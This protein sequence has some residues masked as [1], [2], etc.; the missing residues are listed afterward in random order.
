MNFSEIEKKWQKNWENSECFKSKI[1]EEKPKYYVLEM[2]PYPSGKIHIG[3]LRNYSMGDLLA[4]FHRANGKNVL[5]PMGWDA[6]GLPAENAA[7][8]NN[9][10]PQEW[11]NKNIELMRSQIKAMGNSYD[12]NR[13]INTSSP[14]YYKHEQEFFINLLDKGIAYQ[15]KAIVNWDPVDQTVLANEQVENGRGWRSGALVE[16]KELNGWFLKI[17][18]YAEELLQDIPTKLSE[19]PE[20][21]KHMQENWI[22]K[23]YGAT[24][25]FPIKG[26]EKSLEIYTTR[27]ET[28]FGATFIAVNPE[29][30]ILQY[31]NNDKK[32]IEFIEKCKKSPLKGEELD[33]MPKE[34]IYTGLNAIH[35]FETNKEI[36]IYIANYVLADYAT[37]AIFACP[38]HDERDFEFAKKYNLEIKQV[39]NNDQEEINIENKPFTGDGT[40]I[41]SNFLNG[42]DLDQGK[43][44]AIEQLQEKQIGTSTV[45]YKLKDWGIS[46]QRYWGCPIPVIHCDDCG[47]K[48]VPKADL[49]VKLPDN[50]KIT[51]KGNILDTHPTW[52]YTKCPNCKK[53]AVRETDTFDTFFE[54][55]WYFARFCNSSYEKMV[56][57]KSTNYWMPVD[58]YIGGVEHAVLHLL[59]AR[60]FTKVMCD[61]G[62]INIREPFKRLLTQGMVLHKTYKDKKGNWLYPSQVINNNG[63]FFHEETGEEVYQGKLEK[64]SKSKKNVIDLEKILKRFGADTL[65]LFILSDSPPERDLE[66]SDSGVEGCYKFLCKIY[67]IAEKLASINPQ[68]AEDNELIYFTHETIKLTTKDIKEYHFNKAIAR[69]RELFNK[70]PTKINESSSKSIAFAYENIIKLL[71]PFTPHITEEI[72]HILENGEKHMLANSLWPEFDES[73][74]AKRNIKLAVQVNGKLRSTIEVP[75]SISKN[76][77]EDIAKNKPE[78]AKYLTNCTIKK[79]IVVPGKIVNFVVQ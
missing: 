15:K 57:K 59:Y 16:K 56:D 43:K 11:T 22:G 33:K 46:R 30:E 64:M 26:I 32:I 39:I 36:P 79:V 72:N 14:E 1:D 2:F 53:D 38:A 5:Y 28:I 54:S 55:S 48:P 6:F 29:H 50:V 40:L 23:S 58:Q 45:N 21:V 66:W 52:K 27:Q 37:G 77:I 61:L 8:D 47:I 9:V 12:W 10:T 7:A 13:E 78:V 3:H 42:L 49:P 51:G 24:I 69:I 71:N 20:S 19:W 34:G 70:I 35:P 75:H 68:G 31:A 63:E 4:R 41:N 44:K 17:T 60:F 18:D 74:L 65:R 76:E 67:N 25:K 62:Y 73:I